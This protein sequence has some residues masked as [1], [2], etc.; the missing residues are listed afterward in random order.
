VDDQQLRSLTELPFDEC[1]SDA[2]ADPVHG[3]ASNSSNAA[4]DHPWRGLPLARAKQA[5]PALPSGM[6]KAIV[7][8]LCAAG[9]ESGAPVDG[10]V[11]VPRFDRPRGALW[12]PSLGAWQR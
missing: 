9:L 7:A 8:R 6:G 3:D 4:A 5:C 10:A 11:L 12:R 2:R 1:E